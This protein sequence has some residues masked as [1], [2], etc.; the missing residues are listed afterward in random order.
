MPDWEECQMTL[1]LPERY[2]STIAYMTRFRAKKEGDKSS[3]LVFSNNRT[4]NP[5][6]PLSAASIFET[7][8]PELR[9]GEGDSISIAQRRYRAVTLMQP[10][11]E[12]KGGELTIAL[13]SMLLDLATKPPAPYREVGGKLFRQL[14]ED[15]DIVTRFSGP[16]FA[17]AL[18]KVAYAYLATDVDAQDLKLNQAG[19]L[20]IRQL[21]KKNSLVAD[22]VLRVLQVPGSDV[23]R[24]KR[25]LEAALREAD[26]K[27]VTG[28]DRNAMR[29]RFVES[30][31]RLR[32][33]VLI[34][35]NTAD[36]TIARILGIEPKDDIAKDRTMWFRDWV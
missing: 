4:D 10:E 27:A 34:G 36:K 29:E 33:E 35:G 28:A 22:A 30:L 1:T 9:L 25:T 18:L 12:P 15:L 21:L 2:A 24:A 6:A 14:L 26:I 7:L 20:Q 19:P 23:P 32:D 17:R 3:I 11:A 8:K 5:D 13:D 31:M 16:K